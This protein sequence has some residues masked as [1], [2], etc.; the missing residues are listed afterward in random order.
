MKFEI[1]QQDLLPAIQS[2]S[3]SVGVRANL[4]VLNNILLSTQDGKLKIAATNLEI[5]IIKFI[6]ANIIEDGETTVP[7]KTIHELISTLGSTK[8]TLE[9]KGDVL[10]VISGKFKASINGISASEFPV[11]PTDTAEA[12]NF[13]KDILKAY[14]RV[15]FAASVDGG[16]PQL[17]GVL[18]EAHP[19]KLDLVATDGFRL[20]HQQISL[21]GQKITFKTLI[22]KKTLE[23]VL[24]IIDE[25][26]GSLDSSSNEG[27]SISTTQNQIIFKIGLNLVS[28]R[29]IEGNFPSWEKI[30]PTEHTTRV[31]IEKAKLSQAIKLASV[32]AKTEANVI[33]FD[34]TPESIVVTSETK[35][36]GDQTNEVEAQVEGQPLKI[37]FSARFLADAVSA[38]E[39]TSLVIEFSSPLSPARI[40][41]VGIEGL[42]Y[43][44]MP[45]RQS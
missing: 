17:A 35:E 4:P 18:T 11:I 22:P 38:S 3:R 23:E 30:I 1:L 34:I 31:I 21:P 40:S 24:R 14:G 43:I 42:E 44:V 13:N 10:T 12:V 8:L 15:M 20:A 16:R 37:A 32:F 5:G 29:L 36:V 19:G 2:V 9:T 45:V 7:A 26:K 41:P 39:A 33:T 6:S 28:S 25:E 27:I